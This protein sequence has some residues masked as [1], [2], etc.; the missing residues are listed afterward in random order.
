VSVSADPREVSKR[1]PKSIED[2]AALVGSYT[3]TDLLV[4]ALPA[5]A[6]VLV[7]QVLVPPETTIQ[8]SRVRQ[9]TLPLGV[10]GAVLGAVG[11][12][13]APTHRA[14]DEWLTTMLA[15]RR[16]PAQQSH[17]TASDHTQVERVYPEADAIER[18]D[19]ALVGFVRV[20]PPS[21]ALATDA[22]WREQAAGF[23]DF[24]N[25]TVDFPIQL[26]ATTRP[27]D[28]E[29]YLQ[30]FKDRL[31]DPDVRDNPQLTALIEE[32]VGWYAADLERRQATIRDHYV[33]V[34]IR[35]DEVRFEDESIV[36]KLT[37]LPMLGV[38]LTVWLAPRVED[39][40]AAMLDQLDER[41]RL[42]ARGLRDLDGVTTSRVPADEATELVA[43]FWRGESVSLDDSGQVLHS[44]PVIRGA[45]T[46]GR[47]DV[48]TGSDSAATNGIRD[49][50]DMAPDSA[51]PGDESDPEDVDRDADSR[52]AEVSERGPA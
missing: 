34:P 11:V 44:A 45:A 17:A 39:E 2:G 1:V 3:V 22:E 40:R 38:F 18:A 6:V 19:G 42:V 28:V 12:Y 41:L 8:G 27:F 43:A 16:R 48:D 26:Y 5:V 30:H 13:L 52:P 36:Q 14:T 31:D 20:D 21:M 29:A 33:V 47:D 37:R 46:A 15:Y 10:A 25:T 7:V 49:R 51:S 32:Y 9:F 4:T 50:G 23:Q 24:L 35:P